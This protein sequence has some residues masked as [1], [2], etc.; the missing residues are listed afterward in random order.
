MNVMT[1]SK[2]DSILPLCMMLN[3]RSVNNKAD[4]FMD[5]YQLGP[6]LILTSETWE[7]GRHPLNNIIGTSQYQS[8]SYHREGKRK[9]GGCAITF[10]NSRF[11][12][13]KLSVD[14][15]AGVEA[16]WALVTPRKDTSR[17]K[18]KRIA[19]GSFYISPNS[20]YK[21]T[22]IDH[23][24]ETVQLLRAKFNNEVNFLMGGDVN[25]LNIKLFLDSFGAL[26]QCVTT[27]T[28][29]EAILEIILSDISQLYHPPTT[30]PPLQADPD[31][32]GSDSDHNI[33]IFAPLNNPDYQIKRSKKSI[34]YRPMPESKII[35]FENEMIN[36]DWTKIYGAKTVDEKVNNFHE[37][38]RST[39]EKHFPERTTRISNLDKNWMSPRLKS[40]YRRVQREYY[41]HRRSQ[42][43]RQLKVRFK[44]EKRKA[45]KLFYANFVSELKTTNPG[46]WYK[47]AKRIGAVD[48]SN[49]DDIIVESLRHLDNGSCARQI[50][51]HYATI[52]TQYS[53]INTDLL[54]CYLPAEK[55]PQVEEFQVYHRLKRL[56]KTKSTLPI[57][58]PEKLRLA[59]SVELAGPIT[60]IINTSLTQSQYPKLWQKEWVTP[61]PKVTHP[62][63]IKDLRKISCTSDFS[64]L[65]EG[66][67][68]EWIIEDIYD[69]LDIGQY[70]GQKGT[71]TE[72]MIVCLLDR[73]LKLL[74]KNPDKSAVIAAS[75]DWAS[76]FD[77]QDPTIAIKKFLDLGVRPSL[78]PLLISYLS[79]RQM[80]VK[81]NGEES[82]F[83]RLIGGGPQ[84]TLI[85]QLEY[86]VYSND[87]A[88]AVAK[89]DRYKY[90]DDLTVL[91]LVLL[92]GLLTEYDFKTH[93]A[94]DIGLGQAYLPSSTFK[95]Q[96]HL[97][98]IATWSDENLV[99]LN[100]E[101]CN[102]MIF[103]R[104]QQDFATRL[105]INDKKIEQINVTKV[106]G[107]WISEDLSW[108]RNTTEICRRAYSRM[109]MLTKLKYA[110]VSTADLLDVYKLFIRSITEYCSVCFHSSLTVGQATDIERIQKVSLK[111]ILG[112]AYTTYTDALSIT[113]LQTLHDRREK[114][115]LDF[116]TKCLKH[117]VH[118]RLFPLNN[119]Q[120]SHSAD[121]RY[122]EQ[123]KV[124]FARTESYRKS[125]IPYCQRMLN[126]H[127]Q[128]KNKK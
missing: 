20:M 7:R 91:Q 80:K 16:V 108:D 77:K 22:T 42:K 87:S 95:T 86:L 10:N 105:M 67:L 98:S 39:L 13:E 112:G 93:V 100:E 61:V 49:G 73:I 53:P 38:L 18:I 11:M 128:T 17:C 123:F 74:D 122:R 124:N 103:S 89:D 96:E 109:S 8:I 72:H 5:L 81:F 88:D 94:S 71:G 125:A 127:Y 40:L 117:P 101:K 2:H 82:E 51:Q 104:A 41:R 50:A 68:K 56:K 126:S 92:S 24:I 36:Y 69:K 21:H 45:V 37:Y 121:I 29:R 32:G 60:D 34:K 9:G 35:E 19:V 14:I 15:P 111:I 47:M 64:K 1:K 116:A 55:P 70:G 85:G 78:I 46:R 110:G 66:F 43:W 75:L 119:N 6:D 30:L 99:K 25:R 118:S 102:Y 83:Y 28:R 59:C 12:V 114:R 31:K 115:C 113:G 23:I 44:R 97:D 76:A 48:R 65:Y 33:V 57:D 120:E 63:E 58:L 106:L 4:H 27:P 52:S 26:K 79:D 54:P 62:Q 84:G 3:A 90:V 107:I